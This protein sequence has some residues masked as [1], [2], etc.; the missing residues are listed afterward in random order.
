MRVPMEI[1][2]GEVRNRLGGPSGRHLAH[3][4]EA[5]Q[6]L[7]D[8]DVR[9]MGRMKLVPVADDAGFDAPAERSL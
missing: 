7:N 8:F 2:V 4:H 1:K 6:G 5:P 3:S 9:E